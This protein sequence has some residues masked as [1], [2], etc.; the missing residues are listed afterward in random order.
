MP[1]HALELH[2]TFARY[3]SWMNGKLLDSCSQLRDD[4][5]KKPLSVPFGSLHGLW[6]HL[7]VADN[8][9]LSRFEE[10]PLPFKFRGLDRELYADWNELKTARTTLDG[11]ICDFANGLNE[12]RLSSIL[13]W[14]PATSPT[15]RQM[16]FW[17]V[18]AHFWNHQTHHRGQITC[19]MELLGA[20]CG[21]T[22]LLMLPD[23]P[24]L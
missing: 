10:T 4:A 8:I 1:F 21:V 17:I 7:L 24:A 5:R 15:A 12:E 22:D 19:A 2:Q 13:G 16:P 3:N 6:N 23:L 11:K 9:W 18:L 14:T 20:D